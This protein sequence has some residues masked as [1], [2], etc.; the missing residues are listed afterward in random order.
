M[1]ILII[2][3]TGHSHLL[4]ELIFFTVS[5]AYPAT[6]TILAGPAHALTAPTTIGSG[7]RRIHL[8]GMIPVKISNQ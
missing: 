6:T 5:P 3:S 8:P 7:G 4:P 2:F 1:H